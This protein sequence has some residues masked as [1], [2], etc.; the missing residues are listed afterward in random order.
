MTSRYLPFA[1]LAAALFCS[2]AFAADQPGS[3]ASDGS[4]AW[5]T[6]NGQLNAQKYATSDQITPQNVGQLV[7]AWE[8]HT[9]DVSHGE[10]DIPTSDWSATPLFVND[11]V[12]VGTPFYRIFALE[13]DTGKVKWTFDT[14]SKLEGL[15][16][17]EMKTRGV[18][19]W[20][21]AQ[22]TQGEA[23]QKIVYDGTM[24]ARIFA[25][26]ADTGKPCANFGQNGVLD[27]NQYNTANA[28]WPLSILQPPTVYK[29]EL[30][31]GWAGKD[32]TD[33][34]N[35]P[36]SVF[37]VDARTGE[38]KW[39]FQLPLEASAANGTKLTIHNQPVEEIADTSDA[40]GVEQPPGNGLV[41]A[42]GP[43]PDTDIYTVRLKHAVYVLHCFQKKSHKGGKVPKPEQQLI[44]ARLKNA[45]ALDR[46]RD[47]KED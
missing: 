6:F 33:A 2:S 42:G 3:T 20:Q 32:W 18:A 25:V 26:D 12:Y 10:G 27:I 24:D 41:V 47:G 16:Q 14:K 9:G 38:L 46:S 45:A 13:P 40:A 43:S 30:I 29:D 1:A 21:A 7:K 36:G 23:C 11:T 37:A 35:P 5:Y 31:I 19:Y 8:V 34:V 4:Q 15:T 22:P 44:D 28:K 17:G 39:R